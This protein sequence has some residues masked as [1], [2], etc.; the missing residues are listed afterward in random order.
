MKSNSNPN[1]IRTRILGFRQ[2]AVNT[3]PIT[4]NGFGASA[5]F[6]L[7]VRMGQVGLSHTPWL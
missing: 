5:K 3:F 7:L 1:G 2:Q 4:Y 6:Y